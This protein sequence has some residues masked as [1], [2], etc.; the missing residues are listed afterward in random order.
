[1]NLRQER[2]LRKAKQRK[3]SRE[4]NERPFPLLLHPT[5]RPTTLLPPTSARK[6]GL[7]GQKMYQGWPVRK[8]LFLPQL[9]C[10]R[11]SLGTATKT[12]TGLVHRIRWK[13]WH[14]WSCDESPSVL[15][16]SE[17]RSNPLPCVQQTYIY[18]VRPL[19]E[20]FWKIFIFI[21]IFFAHSG[22]GSIDFNSF[23]LH[24]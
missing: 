24:C 20:R 21:F 9:H 12:D 1:M 13:T 2:S 17:C 8:P 19:N 11:R 6:Q 3:I 22:N 23:Y 5:T 14:I 18:P 15:L 7:K 10:P 16:V 4:R